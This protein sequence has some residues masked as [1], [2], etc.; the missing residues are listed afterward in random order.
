M[1]KK[2][3]TLIELI[4]TFALAS[5]IIVILVNIIGII[6]EMYVKT[7]V[8]SKLLVEQS[9]LS[10]LINTKFEE[11]NLES[12]SVCTDSNFCY[13]FN[14]VDG[15]SSKLIVGEDYITFN[16]YTYKL[17]KDSIIESSTI[18]LIEVETSSEEINN[19]FLL[20]E[21][22]IKNKLYKDEDFGISLVYQYNSKEIEL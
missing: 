21:I 4:T 12:Y 20:M 16:N 7:D 2:G 9:N 19:A 22:K 8:K 6:K 14:F 17:V 3:F 18:D 1:N 5:V 10:Y 13:Q 11:D 15:T